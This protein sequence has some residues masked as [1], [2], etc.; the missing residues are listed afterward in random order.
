M[1]GSRT[2]QQDV[3]VKRKKVPIGGQR[4]W[5]VPV[6]GLSQPH[7]HMAAQWPSSMSLPSSP[8]PTPL[9]CLTNLHTELPRSF[10]ILG[11]DSAPGRAWPAGQEAETHLPSQ[12]SPGHAEVSHCGRGPVSRLPAAF[13]STGGPLGPPL[14]L[15]RGGG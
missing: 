10:H 2:E 1:M 4:G 15:R 9:I 11:W 14:S 7:S 12:S 13:S 8:G 5:H 3:V 6:T